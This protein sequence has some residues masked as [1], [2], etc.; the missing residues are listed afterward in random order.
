MSQRA[1]LRSGPERPGS[2]RGPGW[3]GPRSPRRSGPGG[4]PGGYGRGEPFFNAPP[5]PFV[6]LGMLL[7]VHI[8]RQYLSDSADDWLVLNLGF[9]PQ[10]WGEEF[11]T[12][13]SFLGPV[14][15]LFLHA[16]WPH[17]FANGLGIFL[18]G[19]LCARHFGAAA[20]WAIFLLGGVGGMAADVLVPL[21]LK[22]LTIGA[23]DGAYAL[24]AAALVAARQRGI[25]NN[26]ALLSALYIGSQF[27]FGAG[28]A[29]SNINWVAHIG[30][31]V[32]G[33][34]VGVFLAERLHR[35][36]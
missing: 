35:E 12:L 36:R 7:A 10:Y 9:A 18:F 16:N 30:G 33:L 21:G 29:E 5:A 31:F 13:G 6:L 32:S 4:D 22:G 3:R 14:G 8:L 17:I 28:D 2:G 25:I 24:T 1:I 20:F 15:H 26:I 23:S 19:L 11:P 27:L 34:A